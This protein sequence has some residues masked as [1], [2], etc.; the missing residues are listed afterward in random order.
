MAS[1]TLCLRTD[2]PG[3]KRTWIPALQ[4]LVTVSGTLGLRMKHWQ[5][6][7]K[8]K[9]EVEKV[10]VSMRERFLGS[11]QWGYQNMIL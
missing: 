2:N 9:L 3:S 1:A 7:R 11:W 10:M 6:P 4:F 8:Q 5:E